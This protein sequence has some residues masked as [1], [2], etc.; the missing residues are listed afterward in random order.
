MGPLFSISRDE[1]VARLRAGGCVFAEEEAALLGEAAA[2]RAGL[3]A[4]VTRRLAGEPLEYI[5]GW[6]AF[7]G[8]RIAVEPGVF[9][10][11]RRTEF[12]VDRAAS[13]LAGSEHPVVVDLCCGSGAIGRALAERLAG[14]ELFATD[15]D[16]VA[17]GC[18]RRN[19]SGHGGVFE[20]DVYEPLPRT[21]R[22][23]VDL[24]T[25]NA[26]YVPTGEIATMPREARLHEAGGTLD[27]GHDGL[28]LQRRIAAGASAWL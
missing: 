17:V 13:L 10:P 27:G 18:A 14:I 28:H 21:L 24:L 23:R 8:L 12:L 2:S 19:L 26:P 9:V 15:I 7:C 22:G 25:A 20:G 16:P 6:T 4:F 1:L 11:R 3:D 5:V